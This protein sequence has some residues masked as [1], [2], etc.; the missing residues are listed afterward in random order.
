[1][2]KKGAKKKKATKK[3]G[4]I[5]GGKKKKRKNGEIQGGTKKR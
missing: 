2:A 3:Q 5:M 4:P 1:M